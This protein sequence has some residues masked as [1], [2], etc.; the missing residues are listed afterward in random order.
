MVATY[1][2]IVFFNYNHS[3]FTAEFYT[4][5]SCEKAGKAIISTAFAFP[6]YICVE[7]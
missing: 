1:I 6:K 7:K 5:D 2:L 3:G 4:K